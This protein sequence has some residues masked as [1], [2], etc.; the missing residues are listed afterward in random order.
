ML[1]FKKLLKENAFRGK[2]LISVDIQPEYQSHLTFNLYDYVNFLNENFNSFG[3]LIF[4]YNGADSLGM[5]SENDYKSWWYENDLLEDII[6]SSRFYDKG[7]A[8]FRYCMD[9]SIDEDVIVNFV[10]FMYD[11][12]IT[13]SREM[14]RETWAKYLR[15]HRKIDKTELYS[16]LKNSDDMVNIPGLMT[17]LKTVNNIVLTGGGINE[18]LKEVEIALKSLGKSYL[19]FKKYTY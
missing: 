3:D 4:L 17:F 7:Y 9:S 15:K 1:P 14:T 5:I 13:D 16:L 6:Q 8:F 11:N 12:D 2:S 19:L 10:K 18:C